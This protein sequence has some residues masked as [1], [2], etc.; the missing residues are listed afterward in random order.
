[1]FLDR[2]QA[3]SFESPSKYRDFDSEL[4]SSAPESTGSKVGRR[5]LG[6]A[7]VLELILEMTRMYTHCIVRRLEIGAPWF[8]M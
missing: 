8:L 3:R 2:H 6:F 4:P 7:R 1:M 5:N